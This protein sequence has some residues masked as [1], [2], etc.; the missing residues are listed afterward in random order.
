MEYNERGVLCVNQFC[1]RIDRQRHGNSAERDDTGVLHAE[2]HYKNG[3]KDGFYKHQ[4]RDDFVQRQWWYGI[5]EF[6]ILY[7]IRNIRL[8]S[9]CDAYRLHVC[10]LVDVV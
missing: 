7:G 9:V 10:W 6:S 2:W 3:D 5:N 8:T 1:W 4:V